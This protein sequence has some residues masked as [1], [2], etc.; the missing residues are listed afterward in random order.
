MRERVGTIDVSAKRL[1]DRYLHASRITHYVLLP[2][3]AE[4]LA[5]NALAARLLVGHHALRCSDDRDAEATQDARQIVGRRV[6]AQT[7]A[8]DPLKV[9]DDTLALVAVAQK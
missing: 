5:A 3:I 9:R 1:T 8:A 2:N 6:D 7:G 4:H